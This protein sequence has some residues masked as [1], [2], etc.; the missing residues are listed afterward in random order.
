MAKNQETNAMAVASLVCGILSFI[1]LGI[2]GAIAAI[3]TGVLAQKEI[4]KTRQKG[5]GF[6]KAGLILGIGNLAL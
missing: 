3:I 5:A 6:A 1:T 4:A 2:I